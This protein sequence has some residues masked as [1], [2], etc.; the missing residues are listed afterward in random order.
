MV[1][2]VTEHPPVSPGLRAYWDSIDQAAE[3]RDRRIA[4][5][6]DSYAEDIQRARLTYR[7]YQDQQAARREQAQAQAGREVSR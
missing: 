7:T 6:Q 4:A 5:A 1:P 2:Q 3:L